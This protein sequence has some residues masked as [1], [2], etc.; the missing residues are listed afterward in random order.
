MVK[1]IFIFTSILFCFLFAVRNFVFAEIDVIPN[2]YSIID[3]EMPSA[4]GAGDIE[5]N[6]P[7][8]IK[9]VVRNIWVSVRLIFQIVAL[10]AVLFTGIR[11]MM[12]S[13][14]QKADLKKS[15]IVTVIGAFL[16]FGTIYI[17]SFVSR[18]FV[19]L[20]N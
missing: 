20:M 17:I 18:I 15:F 12:A 19:D 3:K 14:D 4:I 11:Y 7:S 13:A 1:K 16:T 10:S 9:N 2:G 6:E 8:H 5:S